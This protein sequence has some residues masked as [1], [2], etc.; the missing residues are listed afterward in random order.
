MSYNE[1]IPESFHKLVKEVR[2]IQVEVDDYCYSE[3]LKEIKIRW[4]SREGLCYGVEYELKEEYENNPGSW[5]SELRQKYDKVKE[6]IIGLAKSGEIKE[7]YLYSCTDFDYVCGCFPLVFDSVLDANPDIFT[8]KGVEAVTSEFLF[9]INMATGGIYEEPQPEPKDSSCSN[10]MNIVRIYAGAGGP[11]G[12]ESDGS[13]FGTEGPN[14]Y[15][16]LDKL[17]EVK[18]E[19]VNQNS[20]KSLLEAL[21]IKIKEIEVSKG[22]PYL[23][24]ESLVP[25]PTPLFRNLLKAPDKFDNLL[26]SSDLSPEQHRYFEVVL[27]WK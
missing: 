4:G 18:P 25:D 17:L 21:Q 5:P 20:F 15:A 6:K 23:I 27:A 19:L 1:K 22:E 12:F 24:G 13:P 3:A 26:A 14:P 16:I 11:P 10:I 2:R 9:R 8:E 7:D